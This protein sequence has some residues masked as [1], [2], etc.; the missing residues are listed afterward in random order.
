MKNFI[1]FATFTLIIT[2]FLC[3]TVGAEAALPDLSGIENVYV[4]NMENDKELYSKSADT[5]VS[6]ASAAKM[7]TG[8]IAIEHYKDRFGEIITVSKDALGGFKGR[9]INLK[10]GEVVTVENLLYATICGGANDAANVLAYSIAGSHSAF[11]DMMNQKANELGMNNTYYANANGYTD[12]SM[13]TTAKDTAVLARYAFLVKEYMDICATERYV[14][15]STNISKTRYVFNSNYLIATNVE[16][17]YKNKEFQGMNAGSTVEGGYVL[18]TAASRDGKTNFFV[19]MG[20]G[21]DE[22]NIYTYQAIDGLSKWAYESF[23]YIKVIDSGEMICEIDVS[24]S[25]TVDYVVLSPETSV[26]LFLP[27][28]IDVEKDIKRTVKLFDESLEAPVEAGY[29]AGVMTLEYEGKVIAEVDL[30]TKNNVNR[31]GFLYVLARI[32]ALTRSSKFKTTIL[33]LVAVVVFYFVTVIY[34]KT[35]SNRYRYKYGRYK[36]K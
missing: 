16:N 11:V 34:R 12:S 18:V 9:N 24:L 14:F 7:M 32:K 26:E 25:S 4:Y 6:P 29:V 2:L 21:S 5:R 15:P 13:Y 31:N 22:E 20:G 8:V 19:L 17:K 10:D 28:S 27:T 33:L 35:R 1:I 23:D 3:L 30:I 36:R